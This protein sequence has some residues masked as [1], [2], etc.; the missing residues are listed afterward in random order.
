[1]RRFRVSIA[2]MC[3]RCLGGNE[4]CRKTKCSRILLQSRLDYN[5]FDLLYRGRV[6]LA[7]SFYGPDEDRCVLWQS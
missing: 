7:R 2:S 1:M 5:N 6:V 4:K 3:S